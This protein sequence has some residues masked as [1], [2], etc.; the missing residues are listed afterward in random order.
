MVFILIMRSLS[1]RRIV[2]NPP[3]GRHPKCGIGKNW[4]VGFHVENAYKEFTTIIVITI[5][6]VVDFNHHDLPHPSQT[7]IEL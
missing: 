5:L 6:V 3:E 7:L 2:G 4:D 1:A